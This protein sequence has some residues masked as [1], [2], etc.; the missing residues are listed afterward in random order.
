MQL[1]KDTN[2]LK[3]DVVYL[4]SQC[5][6]NN[7]IFGNIPYMYKMYYYILSA[8]LS[9]WVEENGLIA[10]EQDGFRKKRSMT[11]HMIL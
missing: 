8:R 9:T 7:L 3:D 1:E 4:Q 2:S 5:L 11:D 6:G 10:D